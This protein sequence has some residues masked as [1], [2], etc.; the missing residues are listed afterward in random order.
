MITC[1]FLEGL[2]EVLKKFADFKIDGKA[3]NGEECIK[4]IDEG[5]HADIILLDIIM[6]NGISGYEVAKYIQT[7]QLPIKVIA[8]SMLDDI[9]AIK[10][11]IRFGA[12]GF[13]YKGDSLKGIDTIIHTVYNGNE[14]S[15]K[16]MSFTSINIKEIKDTPIPWLEHITNREMLAVKLIS[17]DLLTKQVAQNMGISESVVNKKINNIQVKTGTK[18]KSGIIYFFKNVGLLK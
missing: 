5:L 18:C 11:I 4:Q 15:P 8:L 14:F 6:P 7:K 13:I 12:M 9:A 10:A 3:T 17:Q 16:E 2:D 1:G